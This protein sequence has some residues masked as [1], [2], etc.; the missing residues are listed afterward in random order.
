[1]VQTFKD[2]HSKGVILRSKPSI[3]LIAFFPNAS[4]YSDVVSERDGCCNCDDAP[5]HI[6]IFSWLKARSISNLPKDL[7]LVSLTLKKNVGCISLKLMYT[8]VNRS[9]NNIYPTGYLS[10]GLLMAIQHHDNRVRL[11]G[12]T[13][14]L[15]V[16]VLSVA[17]LFM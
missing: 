8:W 1:M 15:N 10:L 3:I 9:M 7:F 12:N 13:Q 16:L 14:L 6:F 5:I 2:C 17:I 11:V 4:N